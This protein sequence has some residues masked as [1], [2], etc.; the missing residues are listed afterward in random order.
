MP[1]NEKHS[2]EQM[3]NDSLLG[4]EIKRI[5]T[6]KTIP[7]QKDKNGKIKSVEVNK[8]KACC[9]GVLGG[10]N[11]NDFVTVRI[12]KIL[13]KG[14]TEYERK[15]LGEGKCIGY[16]N[17]GLKIE[18][19]DPNLSNEK[20]CENLGYK[21][22]DLTKVDDVNEDNVCNSF[23]VNECAKNL[24][25]KGCLKCEP[26]KIGHSKYDPNKKPEDQDCI[27]KFDV[28]NKNCVEYQGKNSVFTAGPPECQCINSQL[29]FTL[30]N[31]PSNSI[32]GGVAFDTKSQNPYGVEGTQNNDF[33]KYSMNL[34]KYDMKYQIPQ[35]FDNRCFTRAK[36]GSD[37]TGKS[38]SYLLPAY[39]D[40][41][42]EMCLNQINI[43]ESD[44]GTAY[45]ENIN[46]NNNCGNQNYS[47]DKLIS[48]AKCKEE[49]NSEGEKYES[50][51]EKT[52]QEDLCKQEKNLQ[53]S[54]YSSCEE[55]YLAEMACK[56]SGFDNC[57]AYK[58][59]LKRRDEENKCI[60]EGYSSCS[61][62]IQA[63][64][65]EKEKEAACKDKG[66]ENCLDMQ[67]QIQEKENICIKEGYSSC[68]D[69]IQKI[70]QR[71]QECKNEGY[72]S[73]AIKFS[74]QKCKDEGYSSCKDKI[75]KENSADQVEAVEAETK[76]DYATF[77]E[78]EKEAEAQLAIQEKE[79]KCKDEGYDSCAV[80]EEI[81]NKLLEKEKKCRDE[82]YSS[83]AMKAESMMA[84]QEAE[85]ETEVEPT[86][87]EIKEESPK[88]NW[89]LISAL[90]AVLIIIILFFALRK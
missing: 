15:C 71:E 7:L 81:V 62:K 12:P 33:T 20:Y 70:E 74:E 89:V 4:K 5:L 90:I 78:K 57:D 47:K 37:K 63:I 58:A 28:S 83:C 34:M 19:P 26:V 86:S 44:I 16:E 38:R 40:F 85:T 36:L 79:E 41:S 55:K 23:M 56:A 53:G 61:A 11:K 64:K 75:D 88:S 14:D 50:C 6:E 87:E 49:I 69:K 66:Y 48:E 2:G 10:N 76:V 45:L 77:M 43:I 84:K 42:T 13:K 8:A 1:V 32:I 54:F 30:N 65:D 72:T 27:N 67:T 22:P 80:K 68:A 46:Q 17:I 60:E 9:L 25:E 82:G 39:R 18:N 59:E 24:Y 29:G 21:T 31:S 52:I 3:L 73:C 35:T 51:A